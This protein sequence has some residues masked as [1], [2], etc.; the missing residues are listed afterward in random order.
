MSPPLR[1]PQVSR[2]RRFNTILPGLLSI[3]FAPTGFTMCR[4]PHFGASVGF[5]DLPRLPILSPMVRL[6]LTA[7]AAPY[8][9]T[10]RAPTAE[11]PNK[12]TNQTNRR[13]TQRIAQKAIGRRA[14]LSANPSAPNDLVERQSAVKPNGVKGESVAVKSPALAS[15]SCRAISRFGAPPF[16]R[17]PAGETCRPARIA[18]IGSTIPAWRI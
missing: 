9:S 11:L 5:N 18:R 14:D 12:P 3:R 15:R 16:G 4:F 6:R 8:Q 2:F 1:P 10:N 17:Y 7:C 13:T